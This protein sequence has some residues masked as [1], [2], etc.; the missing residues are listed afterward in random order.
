MTEIS[1][2]WNGLVTGDAATEAPYDAPTEFSKVLMSIAGA[3]GIPT[4]L[5]GVYGAE[6]NALSVSGAATPLTVASG[7]ALVYGT[8]Y[9]ADA[10]VSV[11]IPTPGGATRIDRIV[12]R[13]SWVAQTVRVTRIEG[14][15]GGGTPALTQVAGT[16]WDIPLAQASTTTLGVITL[17]DQREF[18]PL[19]HN[20]TIQGVVRAG[21]GLTIPA[22]TLT[23][24]ITGSGSPLLSSLGANLISTLSGQNVPMVISQQKLSVAAA[25]VICP[26]TA[27]SDYTSCVVRIYAT[28]DIGGAGADWMTVKI[29][30]DGNA[31]QYAEWYSYMA[32]TA[33][34]TGTDAPSL[35][36]QPHC[37]LVTR[38]AF[39]NANAP[40]AGSI[41]WLTCL[42][43]SW[44]VNWWGLSW[45]PYGS[46][47]A[48]ASRAIALFGGQYQGTSGQPSLYFTIPGGNFRKNSTFT[49]EAL[50]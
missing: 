39:D 42:Q 48:G 28:S 38:S 15:E 11:A 41:I 20:P 14:V 45:A 37:G 3:M 6:L 8:W 27:P 25:Q 5:G 23:G 22:H 18:V 10:S 9:E 17:T 50:K 2:F 24:N 35:A 47:I 21:S 13:K 26:T 31:N 36:S 4:N 34:L 33:A 30:N 43:G 16:T 19:L 32:G 44:Q 46:T 29:N 12:L 40:A 7:R 49:V 1:R